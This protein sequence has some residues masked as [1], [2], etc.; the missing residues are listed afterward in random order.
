MSIYIG[1]YA[2]SDQSTVSETQSA[3]FQYPVTQKDTGWEDLNALEKKIEA[4]EVPNGAVEH[5]TTKALVETVVNYPLIINIYAF[6]TFED[7]VHSVSEYFDKNSVYCFLRY[8]LLLLQ[9]CLP[10]DKLVC[11]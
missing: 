5:M 8:T 10:V 9:P 6:N 1:S 2:M 4:C 11:L 7:G 3:A